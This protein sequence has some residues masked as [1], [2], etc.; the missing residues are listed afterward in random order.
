MY[1][2]AILQATF[3]SFWRYSSRWRTLQGKMMTE[4]FPRVT[5]SNID[6][7]FTALHDYLDVEIPRIK[8]GLLG[9][10]WPNL[11]GGEPNEQGE[12]Y[13]VRSPIDCDTVLG[14]FVCANDKAVDK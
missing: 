11:I 9:Q 10:H 8:A 14:S 1:C 6:S 4:T 12:R 7:D 2:I 5:Y 3:R 13:E